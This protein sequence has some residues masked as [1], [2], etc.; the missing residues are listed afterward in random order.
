MKKG[1]QRTP[2]FIKRKDGNLFLFAGLYDC[3][4]FEGKKSLLVTFSLYYIYV[5]LII[6]DE[7][8]PLY[9]F[10]VITT[11]S[12][13]TSIEF[14]HDRMPVILE[15]DSQELATWLDPR[16]P[17]CPELARLLKPFTGELEL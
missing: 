14:L 11:T 10:T 2:Y 9:T 4:K 12:A 13:S 8:N 5:L 17:W 16:T 3:V 1:K 15:N 6:I 7:E